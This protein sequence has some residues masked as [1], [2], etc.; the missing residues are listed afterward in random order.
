MPKSFVETQPKTPASP[1]GSSR[2][3]IIGIRLILAIVLL[4]AGLSKLADATTFYV[5][6]LEYHLPFPTWLLKG[7]AVILPWMEI[8]CGL[9]LGADIARKATTFWVCVMF[10]TFLI[11]VGQAF[12][13]GLD[14]SC[15]CFNLGILGIGADSS[16]AHTLE[17]AGFGTLRN[18]ALLAA[19]LFLWKLSVD[20]DESSQ[21]LE[22]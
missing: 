12:I 6:M 7:S 8:L 2:R 5:A 4:W 17:S 13:R 15:G 14:I 22:S 18:M 21:D 10:A 9:L 11:M 16:L 19:A 1:K 20:V 3:V